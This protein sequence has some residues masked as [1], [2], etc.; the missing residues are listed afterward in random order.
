ML[1]CIVV[2]FTG[3]FMAVSMFSVMPDDC[4][5]LYCVCGVLSPGIAC[6]VAEY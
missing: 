6:S 4:T 1:A 5:V 3:C 2:V